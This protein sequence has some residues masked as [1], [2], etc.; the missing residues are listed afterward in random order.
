MTASTAA[1]PTVVTVMVLAVGAVPAWAHTSAF[2]SQVS[3]TVASSVGSDQFAG[4]VAS[5]QADCVSGRSVTLYR[6]EG[7]RMSR[8][9]RP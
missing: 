5:A 1:R 4:R 7:R 8:S 3:L 2:S 9:R 6:A